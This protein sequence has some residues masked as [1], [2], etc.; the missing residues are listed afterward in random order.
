[1]PTVLEISASGLSAQRLRMN[2]I[3][4]NLANVNTTNA[5]E[6][7]QEAD[8]KKYV[9]YIPYRRKEV[10]F[11]PGMP[12][13]DTLSNLGVSALRVEE[14]KTDFRKVYEPDHPH[15]VKNP[16]DPDFGYVFYPNVD[17]ILEMVNMISA[18]RAYEANIS[19]IDTAKTM[20]TASLRIL[21]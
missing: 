10:I 19:V 7:I 16:G 8:G 21:A 17:P 14:D 12:F 11:A 20:G 4:N 13:R 6:L 9:K 1:M 2:I 5:G 18:S 3:A 15:A